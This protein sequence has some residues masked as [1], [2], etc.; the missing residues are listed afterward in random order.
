MT[1][2]QEREPGELFREIYSL[3]RHDQ[4]RRLASET[5]DALICDPENLD[6]R[7]ATLEYTVH[8]IRGCLWDEESA[9]LRATPPRI[10]HPIPPSL[11]DLA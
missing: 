10:H 6:Y 5:N 11:D 2:V 9:H 3:S 7:L 8:V 4:L 1:T